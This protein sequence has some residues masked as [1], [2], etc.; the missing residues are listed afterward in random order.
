MESQPGWQLRPEDFRT[1]F[2]KVDDLVY[3]DGPLLSHYS[4]PEGKAPH[5]IFKYIDQD[6]QFDRWLVMETSLPH[7]YDY[8]YE[9][10]ALA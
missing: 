8:L 1:G 9:C 10:S 6:E 5:Y 4:A 7:L 3:Y 2:E